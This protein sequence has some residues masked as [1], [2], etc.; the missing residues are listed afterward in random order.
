MDETEVVLSVP[1]EEGAGTVVFGGE[2]GEGLAG[3]KEAGAG[4]KK[5]GGFFVVIAR[6]EGEVFGIENTSA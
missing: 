6:G 5:L 3:P 1:D 2:S 4:L